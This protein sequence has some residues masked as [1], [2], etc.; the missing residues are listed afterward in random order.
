MANQIEIEDHYD[1]LGTLHALRLKDDHDGYPDYTCAY[2]NGD[3]SK[4]LKQAQL[5]KH[6]WIFEGVGL[7]QNL[8][9]K[10]VLDIGC[11]WGP[12][13]NAVRERGGE[14]VGF[15]LSS[16]QVEYC[17][18][19]GLDAR[20]QDYKTADLSSLGTFDAII[21]I[22]A[23]EHFCSVEE[24]KKGER[25]KVYDQFF[26]ICSKLLKPGG[27]LYLQTMTWGKE[28]PDPV[29]VEKNFPTAK[30]T[31]KDAIIGRLMKFYPG[32]WL[33]AGLAQMQK[34]ANPYFEF[35][36]TSN[37]RLDYIETLIRWEAATVNLLKPK[38]IFKTIS[39][40][41]PIIFKAIVSPDMRTLL[42]AYFHADQRQCFIQE[43]MSHERM[44]YK[45]R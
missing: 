8:A 2:F 4:T 40:V 34:C 20:L 19:H 29:A 9:G 12:I 21:S 31:S 14:A 43:I 28:D 25:E 6:N 16:G 22:G 10:R 27:S 44:F 11:G 1:T 24:M 36:K 32:S 26:D 30:S 23:F 17:K 3:F 45:K 39:S 38:Y 35:V 37:G 5:D 42:S 18:A 41:V 33:P 13:L 7:G 15:T